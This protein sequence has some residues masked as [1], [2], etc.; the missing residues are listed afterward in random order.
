MPDC[1]EPPKAVRRSRRNQLLI[2][3]MPAVADVP[4]RNE[5]PTSRVQ[6]VAASPY[7]V[8][9]AKRTASSSSSKGRIWQQGPKISSR[10][11]ADSSAKSVQM[12][13][14]THAPPLKEAGIV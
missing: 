5:R 1:L 14:C 4:K 7:G 3:M 11:T 12:V 6:I 10:T 2:Q 9:F 8:A 13:G